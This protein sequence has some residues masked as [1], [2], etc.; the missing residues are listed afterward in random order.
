MEFNT[1]TVIA[2]YTLWVRCIERN[3][4][5]RL[6]N[7]MVKM[8]IIGSAFSDFENGTHCEDSEKWAYFESAGKCLWPN[9]EDEM[10]TI[11]KAFPNARFCLIGIGEGSMPDPLWKSYY[12]NGKSEICIFRSVEKSISRSIEEKPT[13]IQ[14]DWGETK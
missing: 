4:Y 1:T 12:Q 11:S 8:K 9:Q 6:I 14:W 7:L 13:E 3:E 5:E 10:I 2:D